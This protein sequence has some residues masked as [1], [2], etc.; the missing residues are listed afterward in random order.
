MSQ[1]ARVLARCA[2]KLRGVPQ[3]IVQRV[4][5]VTEGARD[6]VTRCKSFNFDLPNHGPKKQRTQLPFRTLVS[7]DYVTDGNNTNQV[8]LTDIRIYP[9]IITYSVVNYLFLEH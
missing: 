1:S 6:G 9:S 4:C 2:P 5:D 7:W 8:F 3:N